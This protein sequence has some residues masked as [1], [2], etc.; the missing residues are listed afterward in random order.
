M[1]LLG[2]LLVLVVLWLVFGFAVH[3]SPLLI[4]VV[5]VLLLLFGGGGHYYNGRRGGPTL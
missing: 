2:I 1:S 3:I 5:L 4:V